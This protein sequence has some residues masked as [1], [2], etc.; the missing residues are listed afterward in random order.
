MSKISDISLKA[1]NILV[2]FLDIYWAREIYRSRTDVLILRAMYT[3]YNN[4]SQ[5]LVNPVHFFFSK[6]C[7]L[8][9]FTVLNVSCLQNA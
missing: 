6:E 8:N 3:V 2:Y 4:N 7:S 1:R 9:S 5:L